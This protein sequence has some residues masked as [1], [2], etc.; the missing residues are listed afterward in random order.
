MMVCGAKCNFYGY[1]R[2]LWFCDNYGLYGGTVGLQCISNLF[3]VI[4]TPR[5]GLSAKFGCFG[6][7]VIFSNIAISISAAI[8]ILH[9]GL[10]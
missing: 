10:Q 5:R 4:F 2:I 6:W 8:L 7:K 3:L 1:C 9:R